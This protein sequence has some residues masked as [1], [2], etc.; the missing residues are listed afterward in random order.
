MLPHS[1]KV[2]S[3]G[4][5]INLLLRFS[6]EH[7]CRYF[8]SNNVSEVWVKMILTFETKT[9]DGKY[10]EVPRALSFLI[11]TPLHQLQVDF[12][13]CGFS[14]KNSSCVSLCYPAQT[15]LDMP[16]QNII[17]EK[18]PVK[19]KIKEK[20]KERKNYSPRV[21]LKLVCIFISGISKLVS[22][23]NIQGC[24]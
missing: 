14:E 20:R 9:R 15:N 11:Y 7:I 16:E 12:P 13:D 8:I 5:T 1:A 10:P 2:K 3:N 21:S 6:P 18:N 24:C 19:K 22:Q 17:R 23:V 4:Q